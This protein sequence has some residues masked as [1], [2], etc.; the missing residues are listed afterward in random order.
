MNI[1]LEIRDAV[2]VP[3]DKNIPETVS[4][5]PDM[6]SFRTSIDAN[7]FNALAP[8]PTANRDPTDKNTMA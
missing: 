1:Q 5:T 2:K 7:L 4:N 6:L 3:T 8:L